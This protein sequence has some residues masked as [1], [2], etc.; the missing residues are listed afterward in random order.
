LPHSAITEV[1]CSVSPCCNHTLWPLSDAQ[2]YRKS[3]Q[4]WSPPGPFQL[5]Q[6][7]KSPRK[8]FT[9]NQCAD[10]G[11]VLSSAAAL[12]S[13]ASL[14]TGKRPFVCSACGKD[15]P[16][17]KGLNR[18]ARV[19]GEQ[20]G[21]QCPK[22]DKTFVYRFG[23]T[24]HEQMVHSGV[25]PFICPI[26]DKRFVIRRDMET[27]LRVHTGEKPFACSLCVKRFKR[28]KP[29]TCSECG[30]HFKQTGHLK[31]HLKTIHKDRQREGD[32]GQISKALQ[33][34]HGRLT[35]SHKHMNAPYSNVW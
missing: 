20:R 23:L 31:K 29:Y 28:R 24:K 10:C 6:S 27:H 13:H 9:K 1:P 30:K 21:H 35:T 7:L 15:F 18:H 32:D 16:N 5:Q 2:R 17:L 22:C 26:C 3:Q 14:H 11:R 19:H 8:R 4:M 25:R 34:D 12:E 33:H